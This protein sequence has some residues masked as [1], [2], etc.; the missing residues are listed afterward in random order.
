MN[1]LKQIGYN[2]LV[3]TAFIAVM[4]VMTFIHV[5]IRP[6]SPIFVQIMWVA[7]FLSFSFVNRHTLKN[8]SKWVRYAVI[9]ITAA[10]LSVATF[11]LCIFV[12]LY[13]HFLIGGTA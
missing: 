10:S 8:T 9:A 5:R 1:I 6:V 2:L 11:Y 7:E 12:G 4:V 13:F 3:V